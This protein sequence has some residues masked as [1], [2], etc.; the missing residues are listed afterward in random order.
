MSR[1]LKLRADKAPGPD[2]IQPRMLKELAE[3]LATA[4]ATIFQQSLDESE[5]SDDGREANVVPLFQK[6]S[7]RDPANYRPISL[8][9]QLGKVMESIIRDRIL[10]HIERHCLI[11]PSQRG[12]LSG[13]SCQSNLLE[14]LENV[15]KEVDNYNSVDVAYL[16]FAKAFDKVPHERLLMKIKALGIHEKARLWIAAW[17]RDRR[18][19]VVVNGE[20]SAWT[21]V[22]SGVPQ[23]SILGPLLFLVFIDDLDRGMKSSVLK[24]ADD[25][26]LFNR[27]NGLDDRD[28]LQRDLEL[29]TEWAGKW[30]MEFNVKKCKNMHIGPKNRQ[31][32]YVMGDHTLGMVEE[33]KD[34]GVYMH[35]SLSVSHMCAKAVRRGNQMA[36]YIYRT[37]THKS[38]ATVVPLYKALVR[39]HLEYCAQV[40][41]P[42]MKKDIASI[43]RV[44]RRVT[45]MIPSISRLNYEER[46][47]KTGLI[48]LEHRCQRG[49]LIEV[50][51]IIKGLV[52]VDPRTFFNMSSRQSRGHLYKLEK[53]RAR[54]DM[55]KHFFANRVIYAWNSLPAHAVES[56]S[57]NQFKAALHRL[58]HEAF[59]SWRQLPAPRGHLAN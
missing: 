22:T 32:D 20:M 13:R 2:C 31:A 5:V 12:F 37:I 27:V 43:E 47:Q 24:F 46:L 8:T 16:D 9:S 42:Y 38:I 17:L 56:E 21:S 49:D 14:Y 10:E 28:V 3:H 48:T 57:I 7:K 34:L 55:R 45:R 18:Q 59:K 36:S 58:P 51:K 29:A 44:Q 23:G 6:G 54:L 30:Q 26:K 40:W 53:P 52:K 19:R 41:S 35:N 1:L 50:F 25:T 33:E 15:T 11:H 39:P 4:I